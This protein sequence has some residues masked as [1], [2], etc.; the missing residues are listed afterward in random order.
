MSPEFTCS[1]NMR[2]S[3]PR[4]DKHSTPLRPSSK[5]ELN[6]R[7]QRTTKLEKT[8]V[9]RHCSFNTSGSLLPGRGKHHSK[10][11]LVQQY[12]HL[13]SG[14][15]RRGESQHG[16]RHRL[17]NSRCLGIDS[18]HYRYRAYHS[19][20]EALPTKYGLT[21]ILLNALPKQPSQWRETTRSTLTEERAAAIS[22]KEGVGKHHGQRLGK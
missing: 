6:S 1:E 3:R 2:Y 17:C 16:S 13:A 22:Y 10:G 8:C 19:R 20:E 11:G 9:F 18:S 12:E 7:T 5:K 14:L 15:Q 21:P 4:R